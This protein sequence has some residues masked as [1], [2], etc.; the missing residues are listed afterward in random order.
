LRIYHHQ[1]AP[2][3]KI[4]RKKKKTPVEQKQQT[5]TFQWVINSSSQPTKTPRRHTHRTLVSP[6]KQQQL[7]KK[8]LKLASTS[9]K[10]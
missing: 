3:A 8:K 6:R 10:S 1:R 5:N 2:D 4:R 7:K 9:H